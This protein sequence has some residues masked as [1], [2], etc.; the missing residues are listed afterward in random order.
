MIISTA[1]KVIDNFYISGLVSCPVYLLDASQPLLFDGGVSC[2]GRIYAEAVRSVLG[3]R[4][5]AM[6]FLSHV[7]WDHCGAVSYLKQEFPAMKIAASHRASEILKKPKACE[8]ITELNKDTAENINSFP[9][10]EPSQLITDPFQ[11]FEVDIKIGDGQALEFGEAKVEVLATPGHT[12]DHN[13]YYLPHQKILI[14]GEAAGEIDSSGAMVT[15]F[16][17]DFDSY[18]YS[19][20]RLASIPVEVLCLGHQF[21]FVGRKEIRSFFERSASEA[22]RFKERIFRL[23][24]EEAGCVQRVIQRVKAEYYDVVTGPKQPETP[25]LLNLSAQVTHLAQNKFKV[26]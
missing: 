1:G 15:Q 23:L 12:R 18:M 5:P 16:I 13:S 22:I 6:I 24:D 19:L 26:G 20:E 14:A 17:S 2:A 21:V 25:Y 10:F 11:S 9:D 3:A 4:Q 7:H 8:L